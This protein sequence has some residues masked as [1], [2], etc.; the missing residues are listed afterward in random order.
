MKTFE[1]FSAKQ[2]MLEILLMQKIGKSGFIEDAL[3]KSG[4][5]FTSDQF[6]V[7]LLERESE[8]I[9]D[10]S[11]FADMLDPGI[12]DDCES[13]GNQLQSMLSGR[14]IR[15]YLARA[16]VHACLI[17]S[18]SDG[19]NVRDTVSVAFTC[20]KQC[21]G[22]K[23]NVYA[24]SVHHGYGSLFEA[25]EQS[26]DI[27]NYCNMLKINGQAV[28]FEDIRANQLNVDTAQARAELEK[29]FINYLTGHRFEDACFSM[30][31][32]MD[33]EMSYPIEL[34]RNMRRHIFSKAELALYFIGLHPL[35]TEGEEGNLARQFHM[36]CRTQTL[37]E[38]KRENRIYFQ[39]LEKYYDGHKSGFDE[40]TERVIDYINNNITNPNLTVQIICQNTKTNTAFLSRV[41]KKKTG[42]SVLEYIHH[43]RLEKAK[44]LLLATDQSIEQIARL[45]GFTGRWTLSRAIKKSDGITAGQYRAVYKHNPQPGNEEPPV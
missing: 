19:E 9:G 45:V 31:Q 20:A 21:F 40:R 27:A 10:R 6:V 2:Q 43:L 42:F 18:L 12:L 24:S 28:F 11:L 25:F 29:K 26:Q 5:H 33:V 14:G 23:L 34:G 4:I 7:V 22:T 30:E 17:I 13:S 1:I 36:V 3:Q 39:M 37:N 41:F 8:K 38:L 35:C 16:F 32:L 15:A 44:E